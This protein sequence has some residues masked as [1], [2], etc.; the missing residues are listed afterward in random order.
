[1]TIPDYQSLMLPLL[2][3][4]A[5]GELRV[6]E[7]EKLLGDELG[8]TP[9]ERQQLLPSGKQ[10]V[11][12]N[13]AHWAKFYL[14]K[15]GLVKFPRRGTFVATDEGR[16][17]LAKNP[18]HIDVNLLRQYPPFEEFY[19]GNQTSVG[20]PAVE[21]QPAPSGSP[22][23]LSTTPE[24]QIEKKAFLTVQSALRAELLQRIMQNTPSFFEGLII[25]L[26]VKM[27]YGGSRPD[28]AAQL[29]GSGDGGVD[30]VINEDRLGLDRVYLQAKR[31][32]DGNVVGRPEVQK[33]LGSLVGM[34]A[35]K[36]VFVTTSKFSQDAIEFARHLTQ[37]I[38]LVDGRR[39]AELMIEHGVGVRISR[40]IEFKRLD[41]NFFDEED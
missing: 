38:I 8:L 10:R 20:T 40:A 31:Y 12:H 41:E 22:A 13:R 6:L 21:S 7:C 36:G 5:Q 11:L 30:G 16:A 23:V 27:G 14:M 3:H 1:M 34:G 33:F 35:T 4:A 24:E 26:L 39:L 37:R 15:A 18:D 9:E 32:A 17:L 29:G 25:E 28:A 2:K 19:Q